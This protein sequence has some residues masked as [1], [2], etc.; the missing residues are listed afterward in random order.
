MLAKM[1]YKELWFHLDGVV[2]DP[3][4]GYEDFHR[5]YLNSSGNR[6]CFD[7]QRCAVIW[8]A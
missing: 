1:G 7:S 3:L 4:D 6:M 2:Y 8:Q 5:V